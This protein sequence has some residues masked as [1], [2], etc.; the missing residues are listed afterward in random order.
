MNEVL[1]LATAHPDG[2]MNM[3]PDEFNWATVEERDRI[4]AM[5]DGRKKFEA[6]LRFADFCLDCGE[7]YTAFCFYASTLEKTVANNRII[8]KYRDIA[9][10]AYHGVLSCNVCNDEC[11][12]EISSEL[13]AGYREAFEDTK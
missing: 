5:K 6:S 7:Y 2:H 3:T 1:K 12:W 8:G 4:N 13:L 10:K 9:N 11:T